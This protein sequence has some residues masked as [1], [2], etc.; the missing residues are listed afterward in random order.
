[1]LATML[2]TAAALPADA[3]ATGD[4]PSAI[5]PA[6]AVIPLAFVTLVAVAVHWI[7]LGQADMPRW[8]KSIRTANGLVMMVTIPILAY[9]FCIVSPQ[10]QRQFVITWILATGLMSLVM[11]LALA[12]VLYSSITLW[13]TRRTMLRQARKARMLLL[14]RDAQAPNASA[15]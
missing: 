12:D 7:A 15:S 14:E 3:A 4:T 11:L 5:A 8:R 9:G 10:Q 6:W 1:M 2:I 13:R